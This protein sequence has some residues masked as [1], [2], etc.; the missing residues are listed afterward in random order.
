MANPAVAGDTA[1]TPCLLALETSGVSGSV[2][3]VTPA[4]CLAEQI[5]D[6]NQTHAQQL[7][8]TIEQLLRETKIDWPQID[9]IAVSLGPGSFTGLRI[10]L[11][12]AKG[13]SFAAAKPLIGVPSLDA[14]AHQCLGQNLPVCAL[15]DA[16]KKEVY[17]AFYRENNKGEMERQSDYLALSPTALAARIVEHT[18]LLGSGVELYRDLLAEHLGARAIFADPACFFAR[19]SS[20]GQLAIPKFMTQDFLTP[21]AGPLYVRASDAELQL[22]SPQK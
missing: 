7:L 19:A 6:A 9:G 20:V 14:L 3:L 1:H 18:F 13:L 10:G 22:G 2:A 15:I 4:G 17:A 8:P 11:S 21:D 5:V 16:R 12:T